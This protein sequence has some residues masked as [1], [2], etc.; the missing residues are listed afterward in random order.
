ML[1]REV[2][3]GVDGDH[4]AQFPASHP[5]QDI[6]DDGQGAH[7]EADEDGRRSGRRQPLGQRADVV[8]VD[9]GQV[10]DAVPLGRLLAACGDDSIGTAGST[11]DTTAPGG[12]NRLTCAMYQ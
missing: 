8:I 6:A 11:P 12:T 9:V 7:D 4:L 10:R 3:G 2:F 1:G 5:V